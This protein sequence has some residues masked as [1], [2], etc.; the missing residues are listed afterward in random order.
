MKRRTLL[1]ISFFLFPFVFL[2]SCDSSKNIDDINNR[3]SDTIRVN[4]EDVV[5]S[6]EY[7]NIFAK[8]DYIPLET[9]PECIIGG[10]DKMILHENRFF[11]FDRQ[12]R[13]IFIFGTDGKFLQKISQFGKGP[14]EY[15][16][17]SNFF[18]DI[19]NNRIILDGGSKF[20]YFDMNTCMFI[21]EERK[22]MNNGASYLGSETFAFY[23]CNG[24]WNGKYNIY[25]YRQGK[26]IYRHLPIS[27]KMEGFT[28]EKEFSFFQPD[29]EGNVLF[30]EL[31]NNVVYKLNPDSMAL[32]YYIDFGKNGLPENFLDDFPRQEWEERISKSSYCSNV[33]CFIK[34]DHITFFKFTCRERSTRTLICMKEKKNSFFRMTLMI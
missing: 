19:E 22:A 24:I 33:N 9:T 30:A 6:M 5:E 12:T 10:I 21:K 32:A 34:N 26:E 27:K 18:L 1:Y 11:I 31:L 16:S 23:L 13:S 20:L 3:N 25:A 4:I 15:S 8:V 14:Q 28:F 29:Q 2:Y 17:L 7:S